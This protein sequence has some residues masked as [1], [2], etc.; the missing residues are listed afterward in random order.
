MTF[1]TTPRANPALTGWDLSQ[2]IS[3]HEFA[4][5]QA[6]E[7]ATEHEAQIMKLRKDGPAISGPGYLRRLNLLEVKKELAYLDGA[8]HE[9]EIARLQE[10][11]KEHRENMMTGARDN[12]EE[13]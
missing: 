11:I 2:E 7:Q 1:N 9:K 8:H 3:R 5:K 4:R 6:Y 13:S 10:E 12:T